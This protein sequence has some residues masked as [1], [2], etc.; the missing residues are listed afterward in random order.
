MDMGP[1]VIWPKIDPENFREI[2]VFKRHSLSTLILRFLIL[3]STL[4]LRNL[5]VSKSKIRVDGL[6]LLLS[7]IRHFRWISSSYQS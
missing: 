6:Y 2:P 4:I 5:E 1:N 3:R 7:N